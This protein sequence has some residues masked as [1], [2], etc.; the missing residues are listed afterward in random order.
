MEKHHIYFNQHSPAH[1]AF[2]INRL[3]IRRAVLALTA[4]MAAA[5]AHGA[6]AQNATEAP[7]TVGDVNLD[8][9]TV[10]G[11]A[12]R[13][14][15]APFSV[16]NFD[17]EDIR[18]QKVKSAQDLFRLV[19]GMNV[20]NYGLSGVA[21][22][23]V[24][25]GFGGGGHGGDL[26][27]VIDGIPLN[28]A[29]SHAD[30]YVDF[31]VVVPLE[32]ANLA[33]YKGPVSALY[34]NFNRSGLVA[35]ETRKEG[36]Y[37]NVDV[38]LASHSTL[39]AQAALGAPLTDGQQLNLAAQV[40]H[41]DGFRPQSGFDR[42][43]V[44]ARWSIA[45]TPT[46][47]LAVAGRFFHG[48]GDSASYL[49]K[50]QFDVDPYGIDARVQNDGS[51]K[52]FDTLRS[53]FAWRLTPDLKLLAFVYGTKQDF[54]RWYTRPVSTT[55]WAQR[56]ESYDRRVAG[57]GVNLNGQMKVGA[58]PLNWVAGI[59]TF[60]ESTDYWFYD[61]LDHRQRT[62]TAIYDRTADLNSASFFGEIEAPLQA[63][64][65][66]W[67]GLRY[68]RFTGECTRNGAETGTDPCA[69]LPS[70]SH[71]SPKLGVR[72]DL[73]PY[74]QLRA[75]WAEGFALP[76]NFIK[77]SLGAAKLDPT[78]FRQTELGAL[79][80]FGTSASLDLAAYRIDS[81]DEVLTVSPGVYENFGATRRNGVEA[82]LNW[83]PL[84]DWLLTLGWSG[85]DSEVRENASPA[86][87][88]KEVTGVPDAMTTLTLA[89]APA[90]GVGGDMTAR[91]VGSYAVDAANTLY[92]DAYTTVDLNLTY[93]STGT[94]RYRAYAGIENLFGRKYYTSL[95]L[96]NGYQL[97]A[98]GAPRTLRVGAQFDF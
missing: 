74:V 81:S 75:S 65:K 25:R 32:I 49:S 48:E 14:A 64:F 45:L 12:L 40:F 35:I 18:D 56:E 86:L 30:G 26:G 47:Q 94:L 43:T 68:D 21:D 16:E 29:M 83:R 22:A 27:A 46:M 72:S 11:Q 88:G 90:Q 57:A 7:S 76:S 51:K 80:K 20:R 37:K 52:N 23:M 53:D 24:L 84:D 13:G 85:T 79:L 39:D 92:S 42:Q 41:T 1:R 71:A 33:V 70:T 4:A 95:S 59:E 66:P 69:D 15:N 97:V 31:N 87:V 50:T 9:V 96:S 5:A 91:R 98:P 77:Y 19:P 44:S 82:K 60:R 73:N 55:T 67:L 2:D 58:G 38:S 17:T 36:S 54:T 34:G 10:K 28:E 93:T 8:S 78:V 6:A 62:S 61:N 63:W 89:Y 3:R